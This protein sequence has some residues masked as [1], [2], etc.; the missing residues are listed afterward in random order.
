MVHY[1]NQKASS[2]TTEVLTLGHS[3]V[4]K[5]NPA[6]IDM[7]CLFYNIGKKALGKNVTFIVR[8]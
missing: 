6:E 1:V 3:N 8:Y 7:S 2:I 4:G 5:H